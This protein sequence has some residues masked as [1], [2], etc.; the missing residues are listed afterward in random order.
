MPALPA[1]HVVPVTKWKPS[2][3][4]MELLLNFQTFM[5]NR[6]VLTCA[7][8]LGAY[9]RGLTVKPND[10]EGTVDVTFDVPYPYK[11]GQA[12][13][14]FKEG[15]F[16]ITDADGVHMRSQPTTMGD[17]W[18]VAVTFVRTEQKKREREPT[19]IP[20]DTQCSKRAVLGDS[21]PPI[22]NFIV[23]EG[24]DA[25]PSVGLTRMPSAS[26]GGAP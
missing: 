9:V 19:P 26:D 17:D 15:A 5:G 23:E 7:A 14:E 11:V 13:I 22:L 2:E 20:D 3:S 1:G 8:E 6:P 24:D 16:V 4:D 12:A 18:K 21:Q 25:P 10:D